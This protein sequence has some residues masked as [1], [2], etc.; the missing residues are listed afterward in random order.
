MCF[1][2]ANLKNE[3]DEESN[4]IYSTL[5]EADED[6]KT[7]RIASMQNTVDDIRASLKEIY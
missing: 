3:N 7:G 2:N 1:N 4:Y 5:V 6:V